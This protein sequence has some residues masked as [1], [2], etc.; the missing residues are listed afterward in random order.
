MESSARRAYCGHVLHSRNK[1]TI[2]AR[3][4]ACVIVESGLV[5]EILDRLPEGFPPEAVVDCSDRLIIPG[6]CD[7]HTHAPQFLQRGLGMDLPLLD[8]LNVHTYPTEA[9]FADPAHARAIYT[10]FADE[11]LRQGTLAVCPFPT[12]HEEASDILFCTLAERGLYAFCGKL[13]MDRNGP[14]G[15]IET[16]AASVASTARFLDTHPGSG[17]VRPCIVPR[18]TLTC[19]DTL[20]E[21]LGG[22][23][24]RYGVPVH[25][26]VSESIE[27][28]EAV[29]ALFPHDPNGLS[30]FRRHGLAGRTPAIMAHCIFP[31]EETSRMLASMDIWA[32]HCPEATAN[33]AAGGIMPVKQLLASGATLALGSDIGSGS[34]LSIASAI[35]ATVRHSKLRRILFPEWDA[36]TFA[37][38]FWMGTRS[39]GRL[40]GNVGAFEPGW[41]FNALV[42]DDGAMPMPQAGLTPVERLERFCYCG[43]DR[44]IRARYIQGEEIRVQTAF[45]DKPHTQ[46]P[47]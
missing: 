17:N 33:I 13:N 42:I 32:V 31:D 6:F 39:G 27:E 41:A 25:S 21:A 37:E 46:K 47:Q 28:I 44:W 35:A 40:F 4:N 9:A 23:A 8:W 24:A 19:T 15:Y 20:L 30:I 45:Q 1:D 26:H 18:F 7:L 29:R 43:D 16:T 34:R 11:L 12:L 10:R 14:P 38:A 22:L 3:E 5:R 36:V 2:V